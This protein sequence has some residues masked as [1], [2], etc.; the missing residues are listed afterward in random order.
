MVRKTIT[1]LLVAA[2]LAGTGAAAAA[3]A[4]QPLLTF[5]PQAGILGQDLFVAN[6]VDLDPGSGTLDFACSHDTYDGHTGQDTGIRS[7]REVKIGVPVYAALD[8]RVLSVQYAVGGD[9]N[10]GP[11]VSRFDNHIILQHGED[12]FTV[13]GHLLRRSIG[14]KK[15]QWVAAG[16][17]I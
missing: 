7:F 8:G 3:E 1:V 14:V 4:P 17:Q 11:T 5:Y 2:T 13:Y 9:L 10:W 12:T 15:G 16:T 6:H